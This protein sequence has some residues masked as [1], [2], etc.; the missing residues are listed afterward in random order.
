MLKGNRRTPTRTDG[1]RS[2]ETALK[3]YPTKTTTIGHE[4]KMKRL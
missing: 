4:G 2:P 1:A 3:Y